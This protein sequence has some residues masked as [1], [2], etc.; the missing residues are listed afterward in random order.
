M[1]QRKKSDLFLE[2]RGT[3]EEDLKKTGFNPDSNPPGTE[4]KIRGAISDLSAPALKKLYDEFLAF[5]DYVTDQI[6]TDIGFVMVSKA[7]YEQVQAQTTLRAHADNSLKNAEMRKAFVSVDPTVVGAQRDYTYFKAKL[8]M[9]QERRDKFKRA[10][11]RIG[12]ELWYRTQDEQGFYTPSGP[13]KPT[14]RE[15]VQ[16]FKSGYKRRVNNG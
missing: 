16:K 5:Y 3:L 11:D 4:P 15:D 12:R 9:Q 14:Q 10:M 7:R 1:T 2:L 6:A 13:P 8:A